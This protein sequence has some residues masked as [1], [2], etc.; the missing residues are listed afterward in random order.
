AA[1]ETYAILTVGDG[2]V[3][4]IPAVIISIASAMLLSKGG[5]VGSTDRALLGQLGGYP[6]ALATVGALM[7][8]L[9]FIPGLPFVP[10]VIG[11]TCLG[12]AAFLT[13]REQAR[14]A[15][16][17]ATPATAEEDRPR[18]RSLCDLLDVDEIHMEF[19]R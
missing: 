3:N 7:A 14:K 17:A 10:F 8:I 2:L 16:A 9:A 13:H 19:A 5:L 6:T 15:R 18:G 4:Q 12:G 11:G 1:F